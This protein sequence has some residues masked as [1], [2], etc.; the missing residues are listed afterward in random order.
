MKTRWW[1]FLRCQDLPRSVSPHPHFIQALRNPTRG[2]YWTRAHGNPTGHSPRARYLCTR[3]WSTHS[4][5]D[6]APGTGSHTEKPGNNIPPLC[7]MVAVSRVGSPEDFPRHRELSTSPS[8]T[9]HSVAI[10]RLLMLSSPGCFS[11]PW[12]PKQ[13]HFPE[14]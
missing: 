10:K 4:I 3:A 5:C 6:C 12:K 11:E 1:C 14:S 9:G 2:I 13:S 7:P 8:S